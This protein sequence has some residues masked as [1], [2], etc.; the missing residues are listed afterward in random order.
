MI[1]YYIIASSQKRTRRKR[2]WEYV[3]KGELGGGEE[4]LAAVRGGKRA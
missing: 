4:A 1:L 2:T 3:R